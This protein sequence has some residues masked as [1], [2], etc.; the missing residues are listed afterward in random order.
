V[1]RNPEIFI[2]A[3]KRRETSVTAVYM[4]FYSPIAISLQ[5]KLSLD[6]RGALAAIPPPD[7][8]R[9]SVERLKR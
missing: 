4:R 7:G 5:W 3:P 9:N 8:D 6:S 2:A 1:T